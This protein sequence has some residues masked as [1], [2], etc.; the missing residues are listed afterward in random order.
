[1]K[2]FGAFRSGDEFFYGELRGDRVHRLSQP[3][4]NQGQPTGEILPMPDLQIDVPVA[5][6]KLIAVGLNYADHI[7]EMKRTEIGAPLIW[8]KASSSLLAH[9]G[10]IEIAF[11]EHQTDFE[12][13]LAVVIGA[14]TKNVSVEDAHDHVFGYTIAL[15]ITDRDLQKQEKQFGRCKSF[16]TYTPIGPYVYGGADV[17]DASIKLWQN[18]KLRQ[19]TRTSRMIHSIAQIISFV[20]KSLTLL[21]G[22]VILT[23]TP[24]GVRPIQ[25]GDEL[26]AEIDDWPRLRN[27]VAIAR[28]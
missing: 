28:D 9:H 4:W 27:T 6:S 5:P 23:G 13:E 24:A 22:D 25:A 26:E 15:D 2:T 14:R 19:S 8:F 11:P 3:Y 21:P 18:G 1:V 20:S 17:R 7:A 10:V 16:D 12:T